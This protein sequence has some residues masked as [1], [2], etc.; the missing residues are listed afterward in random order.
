MSPLCN[1]NFQVLTQDVKLVLG[2][3]T[4][5]LYSLKMKK[6]TEEDGVITELLKAGIKPVLREL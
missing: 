6:R 1:V 4:L 3:S 2:K 5:L